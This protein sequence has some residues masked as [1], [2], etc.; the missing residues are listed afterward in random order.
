MVEPAD[1]WGQLNESTKK[2]L[3]TAAPD[4][5]ASLTRLTEVAKQAERAAVACVIGTCGSAGHPAGHDAFFNRDVDYS[6]ARPELA[7]VRLH[8]R[9]GPPACTYHSIDRRTFPLWPEE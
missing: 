3:A 8:S 7:V 5:H 4:L 2:F 6:D 9:T 1:A